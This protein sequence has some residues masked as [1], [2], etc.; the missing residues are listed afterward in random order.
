MKFRQTISR[1]SEGKPLSNSDLES[2]K[3]HLKQLIAITPEYALQLRN[4][5]YNLN[6]LQIQIGNYDRL[7]TSCDR[8]RTTP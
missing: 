4:L 7:W 5:E 1:H 6:T 3:K 2:L 8:K